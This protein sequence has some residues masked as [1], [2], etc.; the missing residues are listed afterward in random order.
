MTLL[1]IIAQMLV[2][3][4]RNV[5]V[6]ILGR[7]SEELILRHFRRL[8]SHRKKKGREKKMSRPQKR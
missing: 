7:H 8:R 2:D 5:L 3:L 4:V 1:E 6:T